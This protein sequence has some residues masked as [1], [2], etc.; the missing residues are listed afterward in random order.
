MFEKY[1]K[2]LR[3]AVVP[4]VIFNHGLTGRSPLKGLN[5]SQNG[6]FSLFEQ[7]LLC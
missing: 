5:P 6:V 7:T 3:S 1:R 2:S 4:P